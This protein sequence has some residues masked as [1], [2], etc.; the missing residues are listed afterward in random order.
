MKLPYIIAEIGV[1]HNGNLNLAIKSIIA[2]A[3]SGANAVKF[4]TFDTNE[5]MVKGE[6]YYTYKTKRGIKKE[7]MFDMFKRLEVPKSWYKKLVKI[8]KKHKVDFLS[9]AADVSAA[10]LLNKLNVKE[11]KLSSED[12]I[13]YPLLEYVAS[14]GRKTILSTGMADQKEV[15]AAVSIFKAKKTKFALLHC[16]SVYPTPNV[17]TNLSRMSALAERYKVE[18]GFSDHTQGI[19]ASIAA[20]AMGALIIEK[21]FTLSR[22]LIGPDHFISSDPHEFRKLVNGVRMVYGMMGSKNIVPSPSEQK[23]RKHFRRSIVARLDLLKGK[24]INISD[25]ALKR[26][27]T[28][29]HPRYFKKIIGKKVKRKILRDKQISIEDLF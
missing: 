12:L 14:L 16:V 29:L 22:D 10:N 27:G 19:E 25:I 8:S 15:D 18:V 20:T 13:N 4:Q 26:P 7:K 2:A 6:H 1:N 17:E 28:G 9:S 11:I 21:H 24:K 5:F 23:S 3:K